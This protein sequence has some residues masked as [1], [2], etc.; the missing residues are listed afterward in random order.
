MPGFAGVF[1]EK[2]LVQMKP[3][4]RMKKALAALCVLALLVTALPAALAA[5]SGLRSSGSTDMDKLSKL[6]MAQ[7]LQT[8]PTTMP[9]QVFDVMPSVNAPYTTGKVSQAALMTA[10]NRLNV[11]RR[12]AGLPSVTLDQALT[13]NAQ[14]GAV[15]TAHNGVLSHAPGQP[16]D[17]SESFYKQAYEATSSSN[18]Y[19]GRHLGNAPDGF[20]D[21][22]DASN[23]SRLGHRRWQLNPTLGK[24]G[25]GYAEN[26]DSSYRTYVVEK[27]F[28]RSGSGCDYDFISW[29][30]SGNFPSD[31][32]GF[33]KNSAWSVTL[34]P[35]TYATPKRSE[36]TV[37]LTR[38][39]DGKTWTLSG[40]QTYMSASSG[41]YLNVDT[42]GYGVA[43]CI[44]FRPDG[45]EKY[46]GVYQVTINGLKTK[47]GA[48]VDFTYQVDF[49]AA[50]SYELPSSWAQADVTQAI[51]LNLVPSALQGN[52][53][54][55]T[56]RGEFCALAVQLYETVTGTTVSG[57]LTFTDTSDVNVEK[58]AYLGVVNGVG[59][60]SFHPN[61]PLNREQAAVMLARLADA[62]DQPLPQTPADFTDSAQVSS[63]ALEAVGRVQAGKIMNGVGGGRFDPAQSYSREQSITT[64]LNLYEYL[65][66]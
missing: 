45:V 43:N 21:D 33:T 16:A 52:F 5:G 62:L 35:Q 29:P 64:M 17:M 57:R 14:Y 6:E 10:V 13:D 66:L 34:N 36:L 41:L 4:G 22:S 51:S 40:A 58:A 38:Q 53:T 46:E 31:T 54:Q 49:F 19:A 30:A 18:L 39:S 15:L 20:M 8:T 12:I 59:D 56:T 37:T 48:P 60:G 55:A 47:D 7:L 50:N 24:V 44:I 42:G 25:F 32:L 23:V 11:L 65:D 2:G 63:W 1:K 28:D 9:E 61:D 3:I 27:V 26:S